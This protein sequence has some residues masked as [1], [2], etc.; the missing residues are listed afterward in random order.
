MAWQLLLVGL[1][2]LAL[3]GLSVGDQAAGSQHHPHPQHR[4]KASH[5]PKSPGKSRGGQPAVIP[6]G[7]R[8][9]MLSAHKPC[10]PRKVGDTSAFLY[11]GKLRE[12]EGQVTCCFMQGVAWGSKI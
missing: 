10:G 11:V 12:S 6:T 7:C 4:L 1:G 9:N 3:P 2:E 8:H 5:P